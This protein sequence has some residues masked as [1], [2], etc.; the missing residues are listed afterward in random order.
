M[1]NAQCC[2]TAFETF[3]LTTSSSLPS[4]NFYFASL[5]KFF[6]LQYVLILSHLFIL[7]ALLSASILFRTRCSDSNIFI[8]LETF[9]AVIYHV[10]SHLVKNEN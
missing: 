7:L 5:P 2:S 9:L 6:S 10:H 1:C 8:T 3:S 4:I